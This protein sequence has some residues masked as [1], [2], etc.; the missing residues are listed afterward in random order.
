MGQHVR[1]FSLSSRHRAGSQF[2]RAT[3]TQLCLQDRKHSGG[4][5]LDM[6]SFD[7]MSL[8][9]R[10]RIQT[11]PGTWN[12]N[13]FSTTAGK[14]NIVSRVIVCSGGNEVKLCRPVISQ[15]L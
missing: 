1:D 11:N 5:R 10:S 6:R 13:M 2:T 12:G 8:F 4:K 14:S 7:S 15:S 3:S 9:F